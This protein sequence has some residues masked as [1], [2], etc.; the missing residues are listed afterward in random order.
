V[1][2]TYV[3]LIFVALSTL[4]A[5][6]GPATEDPQSIFL[7]ALERRDTRLILQCLNDRDFREQLDFQKQNFRL[8]LDNPVD[9][10]LTLAVRQ[11]P[12]A[13]IRRILK[14]SPHPDKQSRHNGQSALMLAAKAGSTE[15]VATLL[16]YGADP[17]KT[18]SSGRTPY[19]YANQFSQEYFNRKLKSN[20]EEVF[21]PD[22]AGVVNLLFKSISAKNKL[23]PPGERFNPHIAE[24]GFF[25]RREK[26][27]TEADFI[28]IPRTGLEKTTYRCPIPPFEQLP[29]EDQAVKTLIKDTIAVLKLSDSSGQDGPEEGPEGDPSKSIRDSWKAKKEKWKNTYQLWKNR[30]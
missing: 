9:T 13:V 5:F 4:K 27:A 7:D 16:K 21:K 24:T 15:I 8:S 26:P 29:I 17:T 19:F 25:I 12:E 6:A 28:P 3:L 22:P 11:A 20:H 23:F 18:D 1:K 30:H 10:I 2:S 14:I